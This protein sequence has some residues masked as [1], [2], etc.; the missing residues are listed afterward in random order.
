M[1]N[2][3]HRFLFLS[4]PAT[5]PGRQCA[6]C[7]QPQA[8]PVECRLLSQHR[9]QNPHPRDDLHSQHFH[10][11]RSYCCSYHWDRC[12]K[13]S[14][15]Q[16]LHMAMNNKYN[17]A[18]QHFSEMQCHNYVCVVVTI[19]TCQTQFSLTVK[20]YTKIAMFDPSCQH[21]HTRFQE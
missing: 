12:C 13:Q 16:D 15:H 2:R 6:R 20:R 5:V 21:D 14:R 11:C 9:Q 7:L 3:I 19:P 17:V 1:R 8:E 4:S 10:C 18:K